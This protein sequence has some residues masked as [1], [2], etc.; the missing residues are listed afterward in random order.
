MLLG[1][2]AILVVSFV[3]MRRGSNFEYCALNLRRI[4]MALK[5]GD[6]PASPK[7]DAFGTGRAFLAN[8]PEWPTRQKPDLDLTCPVRGRADDID[9]RGPALPPTRMRNED[10]F[11]ADRV[12]NHGPGKGGYVMLKS[13]EILAAVEQDPL[14]LRAA[15]TTSD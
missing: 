4:S 3:S 13:G 8:H 9:Y 2:L 1:L 6:L 15:Q 12:G 11:C 10:P 14:W 5:S 7:W